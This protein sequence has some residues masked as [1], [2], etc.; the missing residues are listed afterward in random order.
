MSPIPLKNGRAKPNLGPITTYNL[1]MQKID[2]IL[3][4]SVKY[5]T[6]EFQINFLH[7]LIKVGLS[8]AGLQF[9]QSF[10]NIQI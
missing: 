4:K 2:L 5:Y 8:A 6:T 3:E 10:L 7:I 1:I 9:F